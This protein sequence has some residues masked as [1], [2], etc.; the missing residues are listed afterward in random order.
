M[1]TIEIKSKTDIH[2]HLRIDYQLN[3]PEK[4]VRVLIM[5]ADEVGDADDE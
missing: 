1:K 3:K 2:G 4:S 5:L